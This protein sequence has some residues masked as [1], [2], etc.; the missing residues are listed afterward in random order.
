MQ[1]LSVAFE[2]CYGIRNLT[3]TFSFVQSRTYSIYAPNGFMK[4]SFCKTFS[5]LC[6]NKG[7]GDLVFSERSCKR[8]IK[9][10]NAVDLT[11]ES[12]LV[13]EPYNENFQSGKASLL[14]VNQRIKNE[15]ENALLKIEEKKEA[16]FR[17]LKQ[18]SGLSGKS[19]TVESELLKV[20]NTDSVFDLFETIEE[21]I[22]KETL[23]GLE[24]H[25]QQYLKSLKYTELFNEK[26]ISFLDSGQIKSELSDYIEKYNELVNESSILNNS[27]N[28]YHAK[29]VHKNL[30]DN[31]FFSANHSIN[32]FD[33]K[34]DKKITSADELEREIEGE[35]TKILSD[36][37]LLRRFDAIDKKITNAELRNFRDYLF[38][39]QSVVAELS[40]Y[41]KLQKSI[42]I[43]YLETEQILL[44]QLLEE[45]NNG[46]GIIENAINAAKEERTEWEEVVRIFNERF[47]VPFKVKVANQKDV[48][49][50]GDSPQ[51]SFTF[52]EESNSVDIDKGKLL[53]ILSQ[54]EKRAL[55]ILNILFEL[56]VRKK[57]SSTTLLLVDDIADSFDYKNKYAIVEYLKEISE[58][59]KFYC[60]FL[61]HNFDFHRTISQ[62]LNIS[63]KNK[64]FAC[65]NNAGDLS[66]VEEKYQNNPFDYW[67]NNLCNERFIIS[68]IPFIRNLAEY[69]GWKD[70]YKKL[71]SLLHLK[72]DTWSI[73][74]RDLN[75]IYTSILKDKSDTFAN[76]DK[77][78]IDLIYE[79]SETILGELDET[80]EL[81]SK[82]VLSIA[83]RLKAEEFMI[84]KISDDSFWNSISNN[85]T[86]KLLKRFKTDFPSHVLAIK[87]LEQVNLITPENIHL[88]SFM[89]EPILDM[90]SHHLKDLY[91]EVKT[92]ISPANMGM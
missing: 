70:E 20:F 61:T 22:E 76:P 43:A 75:L 59:E 63:R 74:I 44:T 26:T 21:T 16:L 3:Y 32:L 71:T 51:V 66:L 73:C 29:T 90:G 28:H 13:I 6:E 23:N 36:Q 89:Y 17:N 60:I 25:L 45:Y 88:N 77:I 7:S 87:L 34:N 39:N 11:G 30:S 14:L 41:K 46:K 27:F 19:Q 12:I 86:I 68:A 78:V 38:N 79:I 4:T 18:V 91:K 10:E 82:I 37:G 15:Y 53:E 58:S 57:N 31:G 62:R 49:L 65:K 35:K 55:Y 5:D 42:W 9:K 54:G 83:I 64:L 33:G 56:N 80:A 52:C 47:S 24:Q 69:C 85:Q 81:E 1:E 67:K 50:K 72:N 40:D 92:M 84:S 48:I 2:N 8:E